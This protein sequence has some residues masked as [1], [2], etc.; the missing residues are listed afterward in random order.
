M[1]IFL[2]NAFLSIVKPK[3]RASLLVRARAKGDIERVFPEA[4]VSCTPERD[5][6][7][8][9]LIPRARVAEAITAYVM[10]MHYPNFK[11]SVVEHDRHTVCSRVWSTMLGFQDA[12]ARLEHAPPRGRR[13]PPRLLDF[14]G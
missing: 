2:N 8:R 13:Q 10:E 1:W 11:G 9:A 7:F 4:V 6:R 5:Y 12:R 14:E 3:D